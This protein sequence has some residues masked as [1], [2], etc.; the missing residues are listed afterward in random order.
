MVAVS[1]LSFIVLG[2]VLMFVQTQR[3]FRTGMAQKDVL[4]TG[5]VVTDML[6]RELAEVT[7]SQMPYTT[8][9]YAELSSLPSYQELPG[10]IT[11]P[12]RRTNILQQVF[13]LTRLNQDWLG[14]G[15]QVVPDRPNA[16]VGTLYRYIGD[17]R[18]YRARFLST[19]FQRAV[20]TSTLTNRIADGIVHLSVRTFGPDGWPITPAWPTNLAMLANSRRYWDSSAPGQMDS[21]FISNAVPASLELEVGILESDTLDQYKNLRDAGQLVQRQFLSN[22]VAQVHLFRQRIPIRNVDPSAFQ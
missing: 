9:F 11:P 18:G 3:A 12:E 8:N 14:I 6:A 20:A 16:G 2:L 19:D 15:Y 5:R 21:Y 22:H 13:F 1:L 4:E 10:T 17:A 7:P